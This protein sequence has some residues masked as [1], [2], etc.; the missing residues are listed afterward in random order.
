MPVITLLRKIS[1]HLEMVKA[2]VSEERG[3][4][5]GG[6]GVGLR[7]GAGAPARLGCPPPWLAE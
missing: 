3:R 6:V 5:L 1:N 7:G 4:E 2:N